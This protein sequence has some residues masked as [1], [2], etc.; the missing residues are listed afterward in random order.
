ML[1]EDNTRPGPADGGMPSGHDRI[2]VVTRTPAPIA[3][4]DILTDP[5][6][7]YVYIAEDHHGTVLYVGVADDLGRRLAAHSRMLSPW[8]LAARRIRWE[9]YPDRLTAEAVEY[10]YIK[11]LDP[12]HN[13]IHKI[14]KPDVGTA[15][16]PISDWVRLGAVVRARRM[17]MRRSQTSMAGDVGAPVAMW[18]GVEAGTPA[19]Y[20]GDL[21]E[22]VERVLRWRPGS[23]ETV[24]GGGD[25]EVMNTAERAAAAGAALDL[26]GWRS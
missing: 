9:L 7:S 11:Q 17:E 2:A 25:P 18:R 5:N 14:K 20:P 16:Y 8:W 22:A 6:G 19:S 13:V 15:V 3:A 21:I 10:A 24:L 1:T 12:A 4:G 23:I 26:V